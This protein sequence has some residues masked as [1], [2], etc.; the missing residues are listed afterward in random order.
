MNTS[1][2]PDGVFYQMLKRLPTQMKE[3]FMK[4]MN[5]YWIESYFPNKWREAVVIAFPKPA[6]TPQQRRKLSAHSSSQLHL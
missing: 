2:G 4:V 6:K 5:K 1:P 3:Y